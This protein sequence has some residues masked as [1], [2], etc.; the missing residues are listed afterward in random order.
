MLLVD[1]W[2]MTCLSQSSCHRVGCCSVYDKQML[3]T[4]NVLLEPLVA[5]QLSPSSKQLETL[6]MQDGL[7]DKS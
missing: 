4:G 1:Q 2:T 5:K 7:F 3:Q 6:L